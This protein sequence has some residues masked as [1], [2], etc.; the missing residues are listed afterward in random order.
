MPWV[1]IHLLHADKTRIQGI[2]PNQPFRSFAPGSSVGSR[3][4]RDLLQ[5]ALPAVVWL[6]RWTSEMAPEAILHQHHRLPLHL[7]SSRRILLPACHLLAHRQIHHS[8]RKISQ[9]T[10]TL[11]LN[12][13][14]YHFLTTITLFT[15]C[16]YSSPILRR[17]GFL[18]S[19][20]P[21]S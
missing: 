11:A 6:R 19:S 16:Q 12:S 3:F 18:A 14:D 15:C 8:H 20:P 17:Y 10:Y 9:D 4:C 2:S 1:A 5:P 21:S 13:D 7:C